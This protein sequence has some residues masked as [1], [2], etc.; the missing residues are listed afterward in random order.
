MSLPWINTTV[1]HPKISGGV[2]VVRFLTEASNDPYAAFGGVC[3]VDVTGNFA[4][5]YAMHGKVRR[6]HI[7]AMLEFVMEKGAVEARAHRAPGHVLPGAKREG[8]WMVI[9]LFA[10]KKRI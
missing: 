5:L 9:D 4:Y 7:R 3:T 10:L 2:F 6:Q 1:V 8:D